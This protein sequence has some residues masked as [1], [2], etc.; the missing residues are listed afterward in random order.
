MTRNTTYR[1]VT[2]WIALALLLVASA[3][4]NAQEYRFEVGPALGFSGYLGD[5]NN[6]NLFKHIGFA[7]GGVLRY[8]HNSRWAFKANL[9]YL[10]ISGNTDDLQT[11]YP[12]QVGVTAENGGTGAFAH[13]D[14][15]SSLVDLGVMAEF[16]FL[17]YGMGAK[18]KKYKRISPYL[19]VGVGAVAA[20]TGGE[21][22]ISW[23]IPMGVGVKYK[24][25]ERMNLGFEFTMRKEF[26]DKIDGLSDLYGV[27]HGFAKN[28]DWYSMAVFTFTY[29]FSKRCVRCHYIE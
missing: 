15:K 17:N 28:T 5:A 7:G 11:R 29:E 1:Y 2:R 27:K 16:N 22:H 21:T 14:F 13:Y 3:T 9:S 19:T 4:A 25:K 6:S 18:Y 26:S 10:N 12:A 23:T 24:L 8:N 20:F